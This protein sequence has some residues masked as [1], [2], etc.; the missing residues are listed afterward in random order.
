MNQIQKPRFKVTTKAV[1]GRFSKL[2][3]KCKKTERE[4][5]RASGIE[6]TEED[7][8]Y[9]GLAA[10]SERITVPSV[11]PQQLSCALHLAWTASAYRMLK[12][13][14]P[15]AEG[16]INLSGCS[17]RSLSHNLIRDQAYF[18]LASPRSSYHVTL[19]ARV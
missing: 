2:L 8:F 9:Q 10:I 18:S 17:Q 15:N 16:F 1:R 14:M 5:T 19:T 7:K 13:S 12:Q 3:G 6:D 11:N 4:E